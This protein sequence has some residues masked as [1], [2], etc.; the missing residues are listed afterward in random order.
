MADH[1][2]NSCV[3][4]KLVEGVGAAGGDSFMGVQRQ[5]STQK[6]DP[7]NTRVEDNY[8]GCGSAHLDMLVSF[9]KKSLIHGFRVAVSAIG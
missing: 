1:S 5:S 8:G 2:Y 4:S 3:V 6:A 9:V 7:E